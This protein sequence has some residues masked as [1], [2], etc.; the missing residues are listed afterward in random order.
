MFDGHVLDQAI[1]HTDTKLLVVTEDSRS[2]VTNAACA[3]RSSRFTVMANCQRLGVR[4]TVSRRGD[5]TARGGCRASA[6]LPGA[7]LTS[8]VAVVRVVTA[9]RTTA[10][11]V[12]VRKG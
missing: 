4:S 3:N 6:N 1:D 2:D 12:S 9:A 5:S 11:N 7:S 8:K 10:G